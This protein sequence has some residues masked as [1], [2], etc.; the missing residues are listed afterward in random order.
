MENG[1]HVDGPFFDSSLCRG[2]DLELPLR[3][4]E[5]QRRPQPAHRLARRPA[6]AVGQ[7]RANWPRRQR[8][9]ETGYTDSFNDVCNIHSDDVRGNAAPYDFQLFNLQ[10]MFLIQGATGTDREFYVPVNIDTDQLPFIRPGVQPIPTINH[11]P[12]IRMESH[13]L[14]AARL[15]RG[16]IPRPRQ[17][18]SAAGHVSPVVPPAQPLGAD[19]LHAILRSDGRNGARRK[20][21]DDRRAPD[22]R[23][24]RCAL[25]SGRTR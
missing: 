18:N 7:R 25:A 10:T 12:G 24:V 1:S 8:L 20:R 2:Q 5:H 6:A 21:V 23:G 9:W 3:R 16:P 4:Q 15:A 22:D 17:V 19:V 11:P 14:A 13:S